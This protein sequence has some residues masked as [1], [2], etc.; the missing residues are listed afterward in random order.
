MDGNDFYPATLHE[1][2]HILQQRELDTV[3]TGFEND[4]IA[5]VN[6]GSYKTASDGRNLDHITCYECGRTGHYANQC[7]ERTAEADRGGDEEQATHSC[8]NGAEGTDDGTGG[9]SFSQADARAI[10][11][12]WV[13]LDD[14]STV[15]Q[16]C[17]PSR[18]LIN[19][20]KSNRHT[21]VRCNAGSEQQTWLAIYLDMEHICSLR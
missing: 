18:L 21:K 19:I 3:S 5:F 1:A 17:N 15:E 10:P 20:R 8:I 16:F 14:Q 13:L 12:T 9:F 7:S 6:A 2:Y 11:A 4:G